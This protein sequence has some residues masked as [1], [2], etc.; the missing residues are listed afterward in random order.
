[1]SAGESLA[2]VFGPDRADTSTPQFLLRI[3]GTRRTRWVALVATGLLGLGLAWLHWLG[4]FA[5]GALVGLVSRDVPRAVT[6]G[7]AMGLLV[8]AVQVLAVPPMGPGEFLALSPPSYLAVAAALLA[9][10][11]GSL[12]RGVI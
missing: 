3:R 9:P 6:A 5:A 10:A 4:L 2:D 8:L 7:L 11:W 1:M 12:G